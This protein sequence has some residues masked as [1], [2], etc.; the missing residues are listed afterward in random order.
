MGMAFEIHWKPTGSD[1]ND[2]ISTPLQQGL[3]A[4]YPFEGNASDMSG[5][6]HHGVTNG[7]TQTT[8]RFNQLNKAYHFMAHLPIHN[9]SKSRD[10]NPS[11][12]SLSDCVYLDSYTD[13]W[14]MMLGKKPVNNKFGNWFQDCGETKTLCEYFNTTAAGAVDILVD[15]TVWHHAFV[16]CDQTHECLSQWIW[17]EHFNFIK[18]CFCEFQPNYNRWSEW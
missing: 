14:A 10:L 7:V 12:V 4:W 6:G 5:N 13:E 9:G 8:D 3:V 15:P 1:L 17:T 16:V 11:M 2:P 18:S